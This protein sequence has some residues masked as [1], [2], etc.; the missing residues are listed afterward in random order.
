MRKISSNQEDYLKVIYLENLKGN[1]LSNKM[2]AE[3]MSVAAPSA[4][5]MLG[6]LTKLELLSKDEAYGF[7]LSAKGIEVTQRLLKK[8]RLWEVF[9]IEK[10]DYTWDEVHEDA[11]ALEHATSNELMERLN[12]YLDRPEFC[13]HGKVIYGNGIEENF[14]SVMRLSELKVG[15]KSSVHIIE[16][17]ALLLQYLSD[18]NIKIHDIF[19]IKEI[20][21]FDN[22]VLL[23]IE[24][25]VSEIS[26]RAAQMIFVRR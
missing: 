21:N 24:G 11:D 25:K 16:D 18:K 19:T 6:K 22:S 14:G 17:D 5:D 26:S 8:H 9:L 23:E 2:I 13:P 10:L 4:S 7:K 3:K 20:N 15:D 1:H 12:K